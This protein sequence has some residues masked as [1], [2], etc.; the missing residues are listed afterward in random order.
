[1]HSGPTEDAF[2]LATDTDGSTFITKLP[3]KPP[4]VSSVDTDF[5]T[6]NTDVQISGRCPPENILGST[7]A[8]ATDSLDG[9]QEVILGGDVYVRGFTERSDVKQVKFELIDT[10]GNV[11]ATLLDDSPTPPTID[12]GIQCEIGPCQEYL[13][14]FS[15]IVDEKGDWLARATFL[16]SDGV[17]IA[18]EEKRIRVGSFFVIPESPIGAIGMVVASMTALGGFFFFR[19]RRLPTV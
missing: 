18:D 13:V 17:P 3:I 5:D 2:G 15:G 16:D 14:T 9:D 8:L 1:M 19:S 11:R 4:N 10:G 7:A 12:S 6:R